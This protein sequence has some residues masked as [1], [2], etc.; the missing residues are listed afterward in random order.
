MN[1]R[2]FL[3]FTIIIAA[4]YAVWCSRGFA[5]DKMV[6]SPRLLGMG[7]SG[8]AMRQGIDIAPLNPA[9]LAVIDNH[10]ELL[11]THE[12]ISDDRS[13][14]YLGLAMHIRPGG[15]L[16]FFYTSDSVEAIENRDDFGTLLSLADYN[17]QDFSLAYALH[18]NSRIDMAFQ[19]GWMKHEFLEYS[20]DGNSFS[21]G[22]NAK[23][24]ERLNLGLSLMNFEGVLKW[25]GNTVFDR[26]SLD[27]TLNFGLSY[28]RRGSIWN[29]DFTKAQSSVWNCNFG[30]EKN[31]SDKLFIRLGW[32][33]D[34]ITTGFGIKFNNY[35]IDYGYAMEELESRSLLSMKFKFYRL[36]LF[37][38]LEK[39]SPVKKKE[40]EK[41]KYAFV[42]SIELK[43]AEQLEFLKSNYRKELIDCNFD[44]ALE[45]LNE[46]TK[47]DNSSAWIFE[48]ADLYMKWGRPGEAA[49]YCNEIIETSSDPKVLL[50]AKKLKTLLQ[51]KYFHQ[52][53]E[54]ISSTYSDFPDKQ[55]SSRAMGDIA[56]R[57]EK[58]ASA[59]VYYK[60]ALKYD[61]KN[62]DLVLNTAQCEIKLG[63]LRKGIKRIEHLSSI[64]DDPEVL[65]LCSDLLREL[66]K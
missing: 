39:L 45:I 37:R 61:E 38:E 1:N 26:E 31:I 59:L 34:H 9:G 57:Q 58:Y 63:Q 16:A 13:L 18:V 22:F 64:A 56:F 51:Q 60:E 42:K 50:N 47:K 27:S 48:R 11:V 6:M 15:T 24:S 55:I 32:A 52:S 21:L 66:Q 41:R 19:L 23:I 30:Y 14:N 33:N 53:V 43:E 35:T 10:R 8:T 46:I 5:S 20:G 17:V 7:G 25:S 12:S 36:D 65:K 28:K 62:P 4:C 2:F 29:L 44:K 3:F 49:V 40:E 54:K